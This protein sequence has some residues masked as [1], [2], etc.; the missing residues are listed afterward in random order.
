MS[1]QVWLPMN[2]GSLK[3]Q[4]IS[5]ESATING[6]VVLTDSG[7]IGKCATFGA[8]GG[9]ISLPASTMT[10]FSEC[11]VAF[12]LRI[13]DWN[14]NYC[15]FFKAGKTSYSWSDYIFGIL[16]SGSSSHLCFTLT[17]NSNS[18]SSSSFISSDL[19]TG[20]WY[21]LA[22]TYKTGEVKIYINGELD[23]EYSTSYV[24]N[25]AGIADIRIGSATNNYNYQTKSNI[26]DVKIFSH[27]LSQ[28]EISE[29]KKA[30]VLHYL[31]DNNGVGGEN[32]VSK[33]TFGR[34]YG[35]DVYAP[36]TGLTIDGYKFVVTGNPSDSIGA[37]AT[38]IKST[39]ITI[40]AK[41]TYTGSGR[42]IYRKWFDSTGTQVGTYTSEKVS[43]ENGKLLTTLNV[44]DGAT[45]ITFGLCY[46]Y[47]QPY[48]L[49]D[50]KVEKGDHST[51]WSPCPSDA[52]YT[53]LGYDDGIE[54][55]TS[56][57][58]NNGTKIGTLSYSTDS[59]RYLASTVF[60]GDTACIRT[61][62]DAVAWQT[63]FTINLWFK[64]NE[65]NG[66]KGYETLFGG[67]AGFEMDTRS[68]NS[69]TLSLYM[70]S[71]R[72]GNAYSPF[73]L[74]EW[75]M[76]TMVND[77]T[78]ELYYVNGELSKTIEKKTMPS[79]DY[80][81]GAWKTTTQQ[82]YKGLIS[83]FRIYATAL[84]AEDIQKLYTVSASIDSNGNAYSAAYVEG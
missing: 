52:L 58:G 10:S 44:P 8:A 80:F 4:G 11:S 65:L 68:G 18:S 7:K 50:L 22:F 69:T 21:H 28:K 33:S 24:P 38:N 77:G 6:T 14:T 42:S 54:Y 2:D 47:N 74:G 76:V 19:N 39:K 31:L 12:W 71:T 43:I 51:P 32:L 73:N 26:N 35:G 75:Y 67:P 1:L 56:G 16:R 83:D 57:Y 81:I 63:N 78:N 27:C 66:N 9:N 48:E 13:N 61:P 17:D 45:S 46:P 36:S 30:L 82:N 64:K 72:G 60:D 15:T 34:S 79:G 59:P 37:K 41:T 5:N 3:Q 29:L 70:T 62:Y 53:T 49:W 84:S 40:S 25:F 23:N 55:D 20:Q